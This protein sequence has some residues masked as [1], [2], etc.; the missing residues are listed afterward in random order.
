MAT[1]PK[2]NKMLKI[3]LTKS[4]FYIVKRSSYSFNLNIIV[5]IWD[6]CTQVIKMSKEWIDLT[7]NINLG[8]EHFQRSNPLPI[9]VSDEVLWDLLMQHERRHCERLGSDLH[10]CFLLRQ[11]YKRKLKG[12]SSEGHNRAIPPQ[13]LWAVGWAHMPR[14]RHSEAQLFRPKVEYFPLYLPPDITWG[15]ERGPLGVFPHHVRQHRLVPGAPVIECSM[16]WTQS[17]R[18]GLI[19]RAVTWKLLTIDRPVSTSP[20]T[21][22][23]VLS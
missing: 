23:M 12:I 1:S 5:N 21:H 20:A 16:P 10:H 17:Q 8:K 14:A 7:W 6:H 22:I 18:R 2:C 9:N 4:T 3:D 19:L 11:A 15:E 13:W